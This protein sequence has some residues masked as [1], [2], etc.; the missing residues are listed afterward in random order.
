[1]YKILAL[2]CLISCGHCYGQTSLLNDV[3]ELSADKYEGRKT[4]SKGN[5]L[6]AEYISARLNA[7]KIAPWQGAYFHTFAISKRGKLKQGRNILAWIPGKRKEMMV[8]S[9]HYDHLGIINGKIYNGADDDASGVAALL[10]LAKYF[11]EH[12]PEHSLLFA[13]FD[14]EEAGLLGSAAFIAGAWMKDLPVRLNVN[15]D[16]ISHNDKQELYVAGTYYHPELKKY[17][18]STV[19]DLKLLTGHDNPK[20]SAADDWTQQGDHGSF[21]NKAIPF[22][23]FG[24]EDHEDYHQPSDDFERIN[25][26][27][28]QQAVE[29]IRQ[30]LVNYD[31][32]KTLQSDFNRRKIM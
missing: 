28:F 31:T 9:A 8:I 13:F 15:L 20:G 23:Y 27:F 7:L 24:V 1:M 12:P 11:S 3:K 32:G 4:G 17:L 26:R 30:V 14:G 25:K 5:L 6:A 2:I 18:H 22:L 21:H 29:I 19:A 10:E 16:M